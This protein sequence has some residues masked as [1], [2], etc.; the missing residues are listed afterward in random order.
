M[1]PPV[2]SPAR[3]VGHQVPRMKTLRRNCICNGQP[4]QLPCGLTERTGHEL[5]GCPDSIVTLGGHLVD[6]VPIGIS[7]EEAGVSGFDVS[8]LNQEQ[9]RWHEEHRGRFGPWTGRRSKQSFGITVSSGWAWPLPSIRPAR[10]HPRR[11]PEP[12][13]RRVPPG[14][15]RCYRWYPRSGSCSWETDRIR[16]AASACC[17]SML[18]PGPSP[19]YS[20]V[21]S[22]KRKR[23]RKRTR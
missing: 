22:L 11:E 1:R 23:K 8:F 6:V 9:R 12:S 3:W 16:T 17:S 20:V 13:R 4:C 15:T 18:R 5:I 10:Y 19:R 2:Q 7:R 21:L 14:A